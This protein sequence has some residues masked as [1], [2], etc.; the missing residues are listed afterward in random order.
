MRDKLENFHKCRESL[1]IVIGRKLSR[2][3][4]RSNVDDLMNF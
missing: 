1:D 4:S 3:N 2:R